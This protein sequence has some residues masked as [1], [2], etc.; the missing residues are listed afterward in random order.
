MPVFISPDGNREIYFSRP[1]GYF[2][3][4][5]WGLKHPQPPQTPTSLAE[6]K[7]SKQTEIYSSFNVAMAASLTIPSMSTPPSSF[8]V[9]SALYDW[10][11]DTPEDFATLLAIHTARRNELLAAVAAAETA[12]AVLAIVVSYAV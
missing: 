11:I 9:A 12:E 3:Q 6:T 5:E 4:S 10:R 8:E 1:E 2:T 7:A